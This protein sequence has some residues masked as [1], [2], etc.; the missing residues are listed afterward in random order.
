M[1]IITLKKIVD[2]HVTIC[3]ITSNQDREEKNKPKMTDTSDE[4]LMQRV[5]DGNLAEMSVLFERYHIRL[6][7]FFLKLTMKKEISQD[8]TQN[9]FYRMI[10]YKHTY[11]NEFSVKSWIYQM[12]R[13]LHNDYYREQKRSDELFMK[14]E[15]TATEIIEDNSI[16]IEDDFMRL[17]NALSALN[18]EHK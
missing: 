18:N 16:Y 8:L 10:K 11:K 17:E 2:L 12:A 7:N 15:V 13:N 9:L 5:K 1:F 14:S 4:I 3:S 6:F